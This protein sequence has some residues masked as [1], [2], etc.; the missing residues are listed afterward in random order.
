MSV[1][2]YSD[3]LTVEVIDRV[4]EPP[5]PPP[6]PST[7]PTLGDIPDQQL[8]VGVPFLLKV[9]TY[10]QPTEGDS[11]TYGCAGALP[12]GTMFDPTTG[13]LSGVPTTAGIYDLSITAIDKDGTSAPDAVRFTVIALA[14]PSPP[15]I[16]DIGAVTSKAVLLSRTLMLAGFMD[17]LPGYDPGRYERYQ[18]PVILK[19][20]IAKIR[21]TTNNF[22]SGGTK[23]AFGASC[24]LELLFDGKPVASKTVLATDVAV[25]FVVDLT[26]I[27]EGWYITSVRGLDASWSVLDCAAYVMKGNTAIPQSRMPVIR[28][29]YGVV[30]STDAAGVYHHQV[31]WVPA[32]SA[33]TL[34]PL[35]AR[36]CPPFNEKP[37]RCNIVVTQL[38]H[39]RGGDTHRPCITKEGVLTTA[40][41]QAYFFFDFQ[42]DK[43]ILPLLDGPRGKGNVFCPTHLEVGKAA[44]TAAEGNALGL[45]GN[46]YFTDPWRVGKVRANGDVV[47]LAGWRHSTLPQYWGDPPNAELVGDWSA[48]PVARRGFHELW[49]M[50]WRV[51]PTNYAADPIPAE[52]NLRPHTE[53]TELFLAD[54]RRVMPN[55]IGRIVKLKF[56]ATS[57]ATPPVITELNGD[58]WNQC[59]DVVGM[60]GLLYASDRMGHRIRVLSMDD[61]HIV[62]EWTGIRQPEGLYLHELPDGWWLYY[63]SSIR[64]SMTNERSTIIDVE[65][66]RRHLTTKEDVLI[67]TRNADGNLRYVINDNALLM[68]IAVSD[69]TFGPRGMIALAT[70]SN[71]SRGYPMLLDGETGTYIPWLTFVQYVDPPAKGISEPQ[72]TYTSAVGIGNG[73][74]VWGTACEGLFMGSK[75]LP[76]D[77]IWSASVAT[78]ERQWKDRGYLLTHGYNGMGHYGLPLPWGV[79]PEIDDFLEAH[80]HSRSK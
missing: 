68:K 70:W 16:G 49:G 23:I 21:A 2:V 64:A 51:F 56:S 42:Q 29:S 59:F 34:L 37:K 65:F 8:Q 71:A 73:R 27:A 33:P 22:A 1:T 39:G 78:G 41:R 47:T 3:G 63:A 25:E 79:T 43:P 44:P 57:H 26:T 7:P 10:T 53:G 76:T 48:I 61:G 46:V 30:S 77:T 40:N 24:L 12:P 32:Q 19:G 36:E 52:R 13:E 60:N 17:G 35:T 50:A 28:G 55:G 31:A 18:R 54:Q 66:R 62:E 67:G 11:V 14:P 5:P 4:V 69:G 72:Q 15:P 20:A 6:P 80:G 74:M 9:S 58:G 38:V 75:A 45:V